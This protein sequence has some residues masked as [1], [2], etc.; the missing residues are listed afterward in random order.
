MYSYIIKKNLKN[1]SQSPM[2]KAIYNT[3]IFYAKPWDEQEIQQKS[4]IMG[5]FVLK[6]LDSPLAGGCLNLCLP[7]MPGNQNDPN[8]V[9]EIQFPVEK[10]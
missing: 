1:T 10:A 9:N 8:T 2:L 5:N 4:G 7:E 3:S 6:M